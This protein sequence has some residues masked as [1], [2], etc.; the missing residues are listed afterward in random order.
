MGHQIGIHLCHLLGDKAELWDGSLIKLGLVMES[1]RAQ[2]QE[3][4][5]FVE[6]YLQ[7]PRSQDAILLL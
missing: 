1:D 4:R 3:R 7:P 2:S 5:K 6:P